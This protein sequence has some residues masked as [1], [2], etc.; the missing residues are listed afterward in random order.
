MKT[1]PQAHSEMFHAKSEGEYLAD[2]V[3]GANDGIITT[4]AVVSG[5]VGAGLP[6]HVI[7]ILGLANLVGD[8]ISMGLSNFLSLRSKKSFE[9]REREREVYEVEKFP[10]EEK[11]EVE[12]IVERWGIRGEHATVFVNDIISDKKRWV[13]F[14]MREELNI[15]EDPNDKPAMHGLVTFVAFL[16]AG[17]LP[18]IPYVFGVPTASQFTVSIIATAISLFVVGASRSLVINQKWFRSGLEMLLVGGLAAG[19]AF[20]I[21]GFVQSIV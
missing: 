15:F 13:D 7:I 3:Y 19:A 8:G 18:L 9:A 1:F 6:T 14:M 5:A 17:M 2:F 20:L 11:K 16:I 10:V 12:D 21:G 4:F